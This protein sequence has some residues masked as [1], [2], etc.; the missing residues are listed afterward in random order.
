MDRT[1]RGYE[2]CLAKGKVGE[3][4]KAAKDEAT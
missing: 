1:L 2:S 4:Q 3:E